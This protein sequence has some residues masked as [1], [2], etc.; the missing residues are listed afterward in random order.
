M[1]VMC[2]KKH[3]RP[4]HASSSLMSSTLLPLPEVCS[5]FA[6]RS[7]FKTLVMRIFAC[8]QEWRIGDGQVRQD[9]MSSLLPS[10]VLMKEKRRS[11][12]SEKAPGRQGVL[13]GWTNHNIGTRSS[14]NGCSMC[15]NGGGPQGC[16]SPMP[17]C[18]PSGNLA[19]CTWQ[20]KAFFL[21]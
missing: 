14:C 13:A 18:C 8:S 20:F 5:L 19:T 17:C 3:A 4:S 7:I 11:S 10:C 12:L 21:S 15:V 16:T 2:L 1:S 6:V 9:I